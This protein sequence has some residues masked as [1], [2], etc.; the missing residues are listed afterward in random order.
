MIL[1]LTMNDTSNQNQRDLTKDE[2]LKKDFKI[3]QYVY[4]SIYILL[5]IC[6]I[7]FFS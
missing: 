1:L 2:A 7:V 5:V 3:G 6:L 4:V